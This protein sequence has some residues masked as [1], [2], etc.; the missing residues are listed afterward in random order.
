MAN[1]ALL[2]KK[3]AKIELFISDIDG[4]LTR[5]EI[6]IL[7]SG[8]EVKIWNV[9][10]GMGYSL[11]KEFCPEIKTAWITGRS[12]LQVK[13][14]AAAMKIDFL[15]QGCDDKEKAFFE[16]IKKAGVKPSQTAY[17]GDDLV[18]IAVLKL[19]G[20][21]VCPKDALPEVKK[22]ADYVSA[23]NGGE[24]VARETAEIILRAKGAAEKVLKKYDK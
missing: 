3:A 2:L 19:A 23:F 4:V 15:V 18:D 9:K 17:M 14:R 16:I 21:S 22:R 10:D 5:G 1:K 12:S 24:G 8:E 7:G 11:L 13:K 6:I 20:L